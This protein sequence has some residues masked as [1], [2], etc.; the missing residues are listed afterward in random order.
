MTLAMLEFMLGKVGRPL[1]EL[2]RSNQWIPHIFAFSWGSVIVWSHLNLRRVVREAEGMMVETARRIWGENPDASLHR[3]YST[4]Q[5]EWHTRHHGEQFVVPT[6]LDFW[7]ER[8][9]SS[10]V[11]EAFGLSQ[12]Y[13]R[14]VLHRNLGRPGT[15]SIKSEQLSQWRRK[16]NAMLTGSRPRKG[17][18]ASQDT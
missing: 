16:R 5:E 10:E 6:R 17:S 9:A 2:Y 11:L 13:M 1:L 12:Q 18:D 7:F 4:F 14:M 15:K 8:M 3:I